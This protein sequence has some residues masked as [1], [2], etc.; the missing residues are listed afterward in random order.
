VKTSGGPTL[1]SVAAGSRPRL[2]G[3]DVIRAV[4]LT[5]VVL[6]NYHGY[7]I[8]RS[9]DRGTGWA[10]DL[11]DPW[12]GPMATR[13]AATFVLVAGVGVTLMTNRCRASGQGITEMRFRLVRR[14]L[15]LYVGGLLLEEIWPGT[16]IPFYGAM[17]ALAAV[18][19]T[20]RSRWLVVIAAGAVVAAWAIRWWRWEQDEAGESTAWLTAPGGG[21]ILGFV[22]DVFVN[23]THPLFPWLAFFCCGMLLAR[24]F[25]TSWWRPA[26]LAGGF[27]LFALAN[28]ANSTAANAF[29]EVILSTGPYERGAVYTA[30]ALGTALVAYVAI[31]W[32]AERFTL[33][34]DPLRRA[35][36]MTLTLYLAH[37]VVYEFLVNRWGWIEPAGLDLALTFALS[38]WVVAIV[39]AV[40]WNRRFG[41]GP[42]ERLYRAIGG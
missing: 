3:P 36:Q 34:V 25:H 41:L 8:L 28:L 24:A 16:I 7:L 27:A 39:A 2:P 29:Q 33:A 35:G 26:A 32:I 5:G 15:V 10:A 20:L 21:S 12:T 31:D 22:Y 17:F 1:T 9:G 4:A 11:F 30:S 19:F 40:A 6:M 37:V 13:F 42:A 14:G 18:M 38:F 23:G